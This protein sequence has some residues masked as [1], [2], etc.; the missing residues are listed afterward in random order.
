ME[1]TEAARIPKEPA[2]VE[3]LRCCVPLIEYSSLFQ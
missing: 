1:K 3:K 2:I